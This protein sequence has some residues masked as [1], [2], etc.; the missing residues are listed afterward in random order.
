M[1]QLWQNLQAVYVV[2]DLFWLRSTRY[3][4]CNILVLQTPCQ[5]QLRKFDAQP[6]RQFLL[7]VSLILGS[8]SLR[9]DIP[10]VR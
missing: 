7:N 9:R 5:C 4:R 1:S 6:I 2:D 3:H 8:S 10:E